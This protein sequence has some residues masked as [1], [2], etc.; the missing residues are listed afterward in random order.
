MSNEK[1]DYKK[2][3]E[4]LRRMIESVVVPKYP[5]IEDVSI[6]SMFFRDMRR[7]GV[8]VLV[9]DSTQ[10]SIQRKISDEIE[11]LFKMSSLDEQQ[12]NG[13][14]YVDVHFA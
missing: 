9:K 5:Q 3:E 12:L 13:R 6:E 8:L 2:R 11:T 10:Y 1:N 14:D 4:L 7:Y